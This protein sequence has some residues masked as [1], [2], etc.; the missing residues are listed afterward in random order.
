ME[1][2]DNGCGFFSLG[3]FFGTGLL[4]LAGGWV[5]F[6][7]GLFKNIEVQGR[8]VPVLFAST[9]TL[10]CLMLELVIFEIAGVLAR[11]CRFAAWNVLLRLMLFQLIILLPFYFAFQFASFLSPGRKFGEKIFAAIVI[12]LAY[13]YAF[14]KLHNPFNYGK[15]DL[16]LFH[17]GIG[18]IGILGV[19][20]SAALSGFGAVFTPYQ[21]LGYF[22]RSCS[23]EDV[24]DKKQE[25]LHTMESIVQKKKRVALANAKKKKA[26]STSGSGWGISSFFGYS[27]YGGEDVRLLK[28]E[29]LAMEDLSCQLFLDMDDMMKESERRKRLNTLRGRYFHILG[30]F[31]SLYGVYKIFM[32]TINIVFR[33]VAKKDPISRFFEVAVQGFG[34]EVDVQFWSQ[35]LSFALVG[36]LIVM[37][38]RNLLKQLSK[39]FH[40]F[41]SS[42][43]SNFIVLFMSEVMGMYFISLVIM[44]RMNM[45]EQY[46]DII[47]KVLGDLEFTFYHRW[48]DVIFL[49]SAFSSICSIYFSRIHSS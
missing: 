30:H 24:R 35:Q 4:F 34:L 9:F 6:Q 2:E 40:V 42:R 31:L 22:V 38:V 43:S 1:G 29:T 21:Y 17:E 18:R 12:Y 23:E 47:V 37:S 7:Q 16:S 32:A 33:R 49:V 10:S 44:M 11:P 5:F 28:A 45:P 13:L 48:F 14:F 25:V 19:T 41:A 20:S 15:G 39:L 27:D 26:S 8:M 3:V 46:R 36:V